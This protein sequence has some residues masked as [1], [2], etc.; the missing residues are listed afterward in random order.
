MSFSILGH[1]WRFL[2]GDGHN[3]T[4]F[5]CLLLGVSLELRLSFARVNLIQGGFSVAVFLCLCVSGFI[6]GDCFVLS[7]IFLMSPSLAY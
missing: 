2:K 6:C 5:A 7:F 4:V 3:F 1:F